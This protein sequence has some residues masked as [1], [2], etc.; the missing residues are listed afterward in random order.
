MKQHLPK[1]KQNTPGGWQ[2]AIAL[3]VIFGLFVSTTQAQMWEEMKRDNI[4]FDEIVKKV[5]EYYKDKDQGRGSGYKQFKRWEYENMSNVDENGNWISDNHFYEEFTR[6][7]KAYKAS[8]G[9]NFRASD[10]NAI[11]AGNSNWVELGPHSWTRTSSWSPGLGRIKD[12]AVNPKNHN[13]IY[14][15]S[16]GG[17]C[18]KTTVGGN[19]WKP[20]TDHLPVFEFWSVAIDPVNT[21]NVYIG[22]AGGGIYKSTNA[23]A[24]WTKMS[25]GLDANA[26]I[27]KI[28]V[29]PSNPSIVIAGTSSGVYRSTNGG[30]SWTR[31]YSGDVQDVE[32]KPGNSSIVYA[33]TTKVYRSTNNG[34]SFSAVTGIVGSG[35]TMLAVTAA[36]PNYVYA[37][38]ANGSIFGYLYRSTD[39]G[40][41]FSVRVTG[42]TNGRN[43]FGY[44]PSGVDTRGQAWHDMAICVSPTNAEEVHIG[45]IITWKSTNG[46]SSF[47][48]T[49]EWSY[50]NSRGY[51]HCDMHD[52][53][54]IGNTLYTASDGGIFKSTDGG[55]NFM[56]LST[57]LGIRQFY[58]IACARSNA[59]MVTGGSQDNGSSIWKGSG[60]IDWL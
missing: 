49:T 33:S 42:N 47:V 6:F 29:D 5:E 15:V 34:Q 16:P 27:N 26:T 53:E 56:N 58:R 21:N 10:P 46:G 39:S 7:K 38:Q 14:I 17:G 9:K 41:N 48:A 32:F 13:E 22:S 25:T 28:I 45:G 57:G 24:S 19:N 20:L 36:N 12:L 2:R 31:T 40:A 3:M 4:R 54:Y 51:T 44:E 60:W 8:Q 23:G 30:S 35:R 55:D 37:L 43:Y 50:P 1:T 11:V 52:L 18:W 59:N